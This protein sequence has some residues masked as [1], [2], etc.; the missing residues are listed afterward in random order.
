MTL[1]PEISRS[2]SFGDT[3]Y[4]GAVTGGAEW[5]YIGGTEGNNATA[6]DGLDNLSYSGSLQEVRYYFGE[7]LSHETLVKHSL[8]PFIYAGNT[9]SSSYENLALRLPLGSNLHKDSSS[10]HPNIDIDYIPS[11]DIASSMSSQEWKEIDEKHYLPTPDTCGISM[12]SDKIRIDEGTVS[13]DILDHLVT[14]R[15]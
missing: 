7:L 2:L 14:T 9:I 12:T 8:D 3:F 5:A 11:V 4:Q 13:D 10:F 6:Y 1:I 15:F